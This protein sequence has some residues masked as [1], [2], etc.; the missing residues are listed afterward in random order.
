MTEVSLEDLM[1]AMA[2][3]NGMHGAKMPA[4]GMSFDFAA[5]RRGTDLIPDLNWKTPSTGPMVGKCRYQ[6]TPHGFVVQGADM[7]LSLMAE[8]VATQLGLK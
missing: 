3:W 7:R 1:S 6:R 2:V 4:G 5:V 8:S